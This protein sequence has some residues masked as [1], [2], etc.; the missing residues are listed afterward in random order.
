[1]QATITQTATIDI[2][3]PDDAERIRA[4][5]AAR[6]P[7][8]RTRPARVDYLFSEL[9][10]DAQDHALET[11]R[12][13]AYE[14]METDELAD[15]DYWL[16]EW[17]TPFGAAVHTRTVRLYGGGT[18]EEPAIYWGGDGWSF[19]PYFS[20][21]VD[22]ADFIRAHKLG[23]KYALLLSAVKR[24][25]V[26]D[27]A[28]VE[29]SDAHRA[30]SAEVSGSYYTYGMRLTDADIARHAKI[31]AQC[32]AMQAE[33]EAWCE[34]VRDKIVDHL[35]ANMEWITGEELARETAMEPDCF[36]DV[37]GNPR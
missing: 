32:A 35:R 26:D 23:R 19:Y 17:F 27:T 15:Y 22:L 6:N 24:G 18:R 29:I 13:R 2:A 36:F 16:D 1:M 5:Y 25:D 7:E 8:M 21:T 9:D 34:T 14:W 4:E 33:L 30:A 37:K 11:L 20:C 10:D 31:D 3:A 28:S 12:S